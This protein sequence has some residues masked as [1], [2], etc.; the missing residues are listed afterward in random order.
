ML[1]KYLGT[2]YN[3]LMIITVNVIEFIELLGHLLVA[4]AAISVHHHVRHE[5]KI[6]ERVFKSMRRESSLGLIGVILMTGAFLLR[7]TI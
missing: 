5:R 4:Y 6:D 1:A 2:D 3:Y 7:F